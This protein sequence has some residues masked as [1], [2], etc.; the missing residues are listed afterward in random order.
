MPTAPTP[1]EPAPQRVGAVL[2]AAGAGTRFAGPEHKLTATLD[3][4]AI[5]RRSLRNAAGG[6]V[7]RVIVVGGAIE[8]RTGPDDAAATPVEVLHA[9]RW[10]DGQAASLQ[11]ALVR[12]DALGW[13][14]VVV[15]LADQPGIPS[16]A[17]AAVAAEPTGA[18]IVVATFAGARGPHPVRLHRRLWPLLPTTG[19]TVARD[20]I[21]R[22]P[23]WVA[24]VECVGSALDIDTLED[25]D[26]WK[27]C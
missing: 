17:W 5:W 27:S 7:E 19:D 23:E 2:L 11:A 26:R 9:D 10:A 6:G 20:L 15:G 14:A 21:T 13:D 16:S 8:L 24:E 25:L 3:G 1:G 18:P 22:R 4:V 12:A